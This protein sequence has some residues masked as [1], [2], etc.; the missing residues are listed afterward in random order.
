MTNYRRAQI[1]GATYFF[2]VACS[3][4]K[5]NSLLTDNIDALRHA[6]RK[7]K[8]AH[9]F[10]IDAICVLPEHLH[11]IWT[12]PP[13]D[14][15]FAIRWSLIKS[16]FSRQLPKGEKRSQSSQKRKERGIWQR[17][18]WEHVIRDDEDYIRHV[19]YIH[20]NPVKHGWVNQAKKWRYSSFH[21]YVRNGIYP[22]DW[23]C[24]DDFD[25]IGGE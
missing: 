18:F 20:W 13:H 23:G 19:D 15:N 17:R 1:K 5:N 4:R 2:T 9:P 25:C 6:F 12:L 16:A 22:Q 24:C 7:V 14:A 11:C 3:E 21:Q 10:T 8:A